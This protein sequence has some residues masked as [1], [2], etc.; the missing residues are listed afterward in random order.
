MHVIQGYRPSSRAAP[1]VARHVGSVPQ[2]ERGD[3]GGVPVTT[4]ARTVADCLMT[5]PALD[6]LVVTDS[7]LRRGV[8]PRSVLAI[9]RARRARRGVVR[10]RRVLDRADPG[11]DSAW[12]TWLRY[13]IVRAGIPR[14]TTQLPVRTRAGAF[15]ADI[16]WEAWRLLLEF[17][18]LVKYRTTGDGLAPSGDPGSVLLAEKHRQ[19]ALEVAGFRVLRFTAR[20]SPDDVV[21]R[22]CRWLPPDVVAG[23][24][25]DRYLPPLRTG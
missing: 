23:L 16:G 14:P 17:D 21:S 13:V 19:E 24:R 12:E 25:P 20:D 7:A 2:A 15:R 22:V 10:A 3:V 4:L 9:L 6:G 1:D 5:L 18:G 8:D 11:A